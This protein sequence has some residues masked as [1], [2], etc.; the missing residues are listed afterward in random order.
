MIYASSWVVREKAKLR[1][2]I[3]RLSGLCINGP[4]PESR[5]G[6]RVDH[7]EVV[8]GGKCQGCVDKHRRTS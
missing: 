6:S 1:R 4:L 3:L 8:S 7:G 2:A 5:V